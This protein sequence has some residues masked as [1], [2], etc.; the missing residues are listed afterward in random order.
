MNILLYAENCLFPCASSEDI[1]EDNRDKVYE[2]YRFALQLEPERK[3]EL[4]FAQRMVVNKARSFITKRM[5]KRIEVR[6]VK[7]NKKSMWKMRKMLSTK[8]MAEMEAMQAKQGEMQDEVLSSAN[9]VPTKDPI[10]PIAP[11]VPI[12]RADTGVTK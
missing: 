6:Q 4:S 3:P 2:L 5:K 11:T 9:M 12:V 8:M 1:R 10:A 7:N